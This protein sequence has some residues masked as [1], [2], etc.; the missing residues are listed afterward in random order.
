MEIRGNRRCQSCG[1]EWSYY[2]T[3]EVSCPDCGSLKSVG[4]DETRTLHTDTVTPL[5][6]EPFRERVADE[7]IDH[8][9]DELKSLLRTYTQKRGFINGGKLR[10]LDETYVAA[11]ELIHATDV[12][13]RERSPTAD[14]TLYLLS[15]FESVATSTSTTAVES[16]TARGDRTDESSDHR[17]GADE[18]PP[19][20]QSARALAV[21]DSVTAYRRDLRTW[22]QSHPDPDARQTL[23]RLREQCKRIT[24]LQG[25]VSPELSATLLATAREI[26]HYLREDDCTALATARERL[27]RT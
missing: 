8:Y 10:N 20:L 4:T 6:L 11:R 12:L 14:E 19:R 18:I 2:A 16:A 27:E 9:A 13:S 24:A 23:G 1:T 21:A 5:E 15:L 17:L 25:E 26:G 22:L 7:P 3:G